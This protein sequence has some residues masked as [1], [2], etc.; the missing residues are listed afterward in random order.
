MRGVIVD[1][2]AGYAWIIGRFHGK[3]LSKQTGLLGMSG[4]LGQRVAG[5]PWSKMSGDQPAPGATEHNPLAMANGLQVDWLGM[6]ISAR[7]DLGLDMSGVTFTTEF[8]QSQFR[9]SNVF[10]DQQHQWNVCGSIIANSAAYIQGVDLAAAANFQ[11]RDEVT[12]FDATWSWQPL[13]PNKIE[14]FGVGAEGVIAQ[15]MAWKIPAI[16]AA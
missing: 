13:N 7:E 6:M 1:L 3:D 10:R 5:G 11:L 15:A 8:E 14:L 4:A 9:N 12:S 16:P 2:E